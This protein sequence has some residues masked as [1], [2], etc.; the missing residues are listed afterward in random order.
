[1]GD[2]KESVVFRSKEKID[3]MSEFVWQRFGSKPFEDDTLKSD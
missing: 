1:M 3:L 2:G